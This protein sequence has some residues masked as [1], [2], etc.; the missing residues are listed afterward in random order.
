MKILLVSQYFYPEN[1]RLNDFA[2]KLASKGHEVTVLTGIPNYPNGK[3]F[4]AFKIL[5][6]DSIKGVTVYRVPMMLRGNSRGIELILNYISFLVSA[7]IFG[8][9]LLLRER[10]DIVFATNYSPATVG[11]VGAF[12]AALKGTPLFLWVHDLWPDTLTAL[13][14]TKSNFALTLVELMIR[15]IYR[16]SDRIL[17]QS[18]AFKSS[19]E[20]RGIHANKIEYF[21]N[22]AEDLYTDTICDL[23]LKN[24]M[25]IPQNKFIIMF[26]GNLGEC[27]SLDT[28][29][30]AAKILQDSP[31][32]W[33]LLGDGREK[34][35]IEKKIIKSD[36]TT[37]ISLLGHYPVEDMPRFFAQADVMLVTL[38]S[39][40]VF[41]LT[42]PGKVQ[43][44]LK[45]GKPIL[46]GLNGEGASI[47]SE[48]GAGIAV[49]ADDPVGLAEAALQLSSLNSGE[50]KNMGTLGK[51]YYDEN[52]DVDML[53]NRF[54]H[55]VCT[56]NGP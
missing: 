40:P 1:F 20:S 42:I 38:R 47:V 12:F 22:W 48:S 8:P 14:A 24:T 16:R 10:F 31:I 13:N 23:E 45:S 27:Q 6:K 17:I 46:A 43:S 25:K 56:K 34:S 15:W 53:I 49:P 9:I 50:L 3:A 35:N 37:N 36:L 5:R 30:N 52:F 19:V 51:K 54:E 55:L 7:V 26:A 44:Y 33:V 32:H 18:R 11:I 4:G 39:E 2:F 28:I 41:S 21:P 29:V